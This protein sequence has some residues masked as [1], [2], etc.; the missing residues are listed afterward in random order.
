[1][2][3]PL[4]LEVT[5]GQAL[6]QWQAF[7]DEYSRCQRAWHEFTAS[8]GATGS[9][10]FPGEAPRAFKFAGNRPPEGWKAPNREGASAPYGRRKDL[11]ALI[12]ALPAPRDSDSV[13]AETGLPLSLRYRYPPKEPGGFEPNGWETVSVG[14]TFRSWSPTWAALD[15]PIFLRG[16]DWLAR[17]ADL[18]AEGATVT[19]SPNDTRSIPDGYTRVLEEYVN[20]VAAQ[21]KYSAAAKEHAANA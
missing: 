6:E 10:C 9:F 1:M 20:L 15:A 8:I 5:C 3:K 11:W 7:R 18:E 12:D 21:A 17:I 13:A 2:M 4:W 14:Y 19:L 16:G